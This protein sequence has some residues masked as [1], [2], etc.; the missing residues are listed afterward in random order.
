MFIY[1]NWQEIFK[2]EKGFNKIKINNLNINKNKMI[3]KF[4]III[5]NKTKII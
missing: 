4:K 2:I 5:Y 1:S 3:M